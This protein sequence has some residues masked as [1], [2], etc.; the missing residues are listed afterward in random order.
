MSPK[1]PSASKSAAPTYQIKVTLECTWPPVWRRLLI[2]SD[3]TLLQLHEVLQRA[4][5]WWQYHLHEF[6]LGE[7][8]YGDVE[9]EVECGFGDQ[10]LCADER[11]WRLGELLTVPGQELLYRYDFGDD[12][13][14]YVLL[15]KVLPAQGIRRAECIGGATG[16]SSE[17]QRWPL[18]G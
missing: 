8:R 1:A 3:L 7:D 4:F 14:H 13:R 2:P 10:P 16:A 12:W 9:V 6:E 11:H 18:V 15:E 5:G 17:R